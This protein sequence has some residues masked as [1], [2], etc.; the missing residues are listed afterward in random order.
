MPLIITDA[1]AERLSATSNGRVGYPRIEI[2]AGGC[3]GFEKC[4]SWSD[5][6][7][8]DDL[9]IH[10]KYGQVLVDPSSY[11]LL[12]NAIVDYKIG[13]DGSYFDITIPEAT[14]TCGCGTSFSM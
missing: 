8:A 4:I 5:D 14:S 2:I 7:A 11:D 3:N 13:L 6:F 9:A 1:A 12:S 10:T